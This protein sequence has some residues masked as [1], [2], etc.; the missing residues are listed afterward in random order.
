MLGNVVVIVGAASRL[1]SILV[2]FG[3]DWGMW[4]GAQEGVFCMFVEL[5]FQLGKFELKPFAL[6]HTGWHC[7]FQL[8]SS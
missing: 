1:H 6:S 3:F 8:D 2:Q 4:M 7:I 5:L